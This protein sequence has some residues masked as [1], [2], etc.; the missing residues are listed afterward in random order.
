MPKPY[1]LDPHDVCLF[2]KDNEKGIRPDHEQTARDFD[3]MLSDKGVRDLVT[4]IIPLRQLK[5]EYK[6]F[7]AKA[8]L[9]NRFD[10]FLADDRILRFLPK[11][12][13]K[14]FYK[15]KR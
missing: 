14:A 6:P 11:F 15:K 1:L 9:S 12:L 2:V 7:E 3:K 5:V 10:K 13:G 4:E 8:K